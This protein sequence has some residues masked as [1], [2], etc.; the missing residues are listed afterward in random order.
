MKNIAQNY[1]KI[2]QELPNNVT[3]VGATK[4]KSASQIRE[5]INA[6]L[7]NI[8]ENYVQEAL[9][10]YD[11]LGEDAKHIKWH[12]IGHLQRNKVKK[13]VPV[14]DLIQSLDSEELAEEINKRAIQL[15]KKMQCLVEVNIAQ[16]E[17]K[18]GIAP[19]ELNTFIENLRKF[20]NIELLGIMIMEPYSEDP[21]TARPYFK[22]A[23]ALFDSV[24]EFSI[25]S[26]GMSTAY[27]I[28]IEEGSTM[29]RIGSGLFG[30]RE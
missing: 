2:R 25:L 3:L 8:G 29:V 7:E 5:A 16:E 12:F 14:F 27:K 17:S 24:P 23:K 10:K 30:R 28:A 18:F 11:E 1:E 21:E 22:K 9:E 19:N 13:V 26:M 15:N 4:D 6:G 20:E